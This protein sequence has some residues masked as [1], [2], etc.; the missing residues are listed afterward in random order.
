MSRRRIASKREAGTV[1]ERWV[2]DWSSRR[3]ARL[4]A[5]CLLVATVVVLGTGCDSA[6]AATG[7]KFLSDLSETSAGSLLVEPGTVTVD[8]AS[9][10]VFVADPGAGMVDVYNS[11]GGFVTQFGEGRLFA[12]GIGV[13]EASGSVYVADTFENE[14][15]VFK[16]NGPS[17]YQLISEWSG[18]GLPGEEF[19]EVAGVA[20]E[21][22][23]ELRRGMCM[24]LIAKTP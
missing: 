23:P 10:D 20:G 12:A 2:R 1:R 17:S 5:I 3:P 4:G 24:W 7:H 18:Q 16:P 22:Q 8:H 6:S 13:D 9:G 11:A 14:V 21:S 15:L 19:G